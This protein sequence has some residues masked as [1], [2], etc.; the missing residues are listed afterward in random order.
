MLGEFHSDPYLP[1]THEIHI[2]KAAH[3]VTKNRKVYSSLGYTASK[4]IPAIFHSQLV[5]MFI[6][7][8]SHPLLAG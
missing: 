3:P 2:K 7:R 4:R 8:I 6:H 1:K 5:F